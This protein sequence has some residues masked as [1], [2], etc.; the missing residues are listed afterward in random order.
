MASLAD[1]A[2]WTELDSVLDRLREEQPGLLMQAPGSG[3]EPPYAITLAAWGAGAAAALHEQFGEAV[4]LTVGFLP[5]PPGRPP[6]RMP[7]RGRQEETLPL[8][9]DLASAELDGP[10]TV[11]SGHSLRHGLL[12]RNQSGAGLAIATNGVIT[13]SVA[14]PATGE[15]AGGYA[16]W[17]T[18]PLV[19]F[20]VA[21][22]ETT[23]IPLLIGTASVTP[24]LGYT[25]PPGSDPSLTFANSA[26]AP[27]QQTWSQ[28]LPGSSNVLG[29]KATMA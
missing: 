28:M 23:R 27:R 5:F 8:D 14:D 25:V 12:V 29:A 9:P 15:I 24:R 13:A 7:P 10:A 6:R 3:G 17:Q 20:E 1:V 18:A 21:P 22:G 2:E 4:E 19:T 11:R 26:P 16:G